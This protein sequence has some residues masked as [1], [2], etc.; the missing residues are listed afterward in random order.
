MASSWFFLILHRKEFVHHVGQLQRVTAAVAFAAWNTP[1][2]L[3]K[4]TGKTET[5][6]V[7]FQIYFPYTN[8][9][10]LSGW[11]SQNFRSLTMIVRVYFHAYTRIQVKHVTVTPT[12]I[13]ETYSH[14]NLAILMLSL[15]GIYVLCHMRSFTLQFPCSKQ[16]SVYRWSHFRAKERD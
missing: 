1:S 10:C 4:Y 6:F 13:T 5:V 11:I 2:L 3:N 16:S 7:A 15:C 9:K 12:L 8:T 14:T